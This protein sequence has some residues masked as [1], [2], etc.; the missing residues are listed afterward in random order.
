MDYANPMST[1][2]FYPDTPIPKTP[3]V[4][5]FMFALPPLT[6][7]MPSDLGSDDRTPKSTPIFSLDTDGHDSD[8]GTTPKSTSPT[9]SQSPPSEQTTVNADVIDSIA[10]QNVGFVEIRQGIYY[11]RV[12]FNDFYQYPIEIASKSLELVKR[13]LIDYGILKFL[14]TSAM[15]TEIGPMENWNK[16]KLNTVI[17]KKN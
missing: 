13:S 10:S 15:D 5:A 4:N 12:L 16:S 1:G 14:N 6:P 9:Q 3:D 17:S 2:L 11:L 7:H 8:I